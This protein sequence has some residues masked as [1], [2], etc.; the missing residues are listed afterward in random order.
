VKILLKKIAILIV[1]IL[2][3]TVLG[4]E[5]SES[6]GLTGISMLYLLLVVG[7]AYH[8]SPFLVVIV[9]ITSFLVMNYFF[10]E[11]R[12]TFQIGH[13][14]SWTSLISFLIVSVVI[15]S[16]VKRLKLETYQSQQAYLQA[17]FLRKLAEKLTYADSMQLMLEDCQDLLQKEFSKDVLIIKDGVTVKGQHQLTVEHRNAIAWVQEN[18]KSFG[19]G[20][21]NWPDSN[22]M[23]LPFNRLKSNDPVVLLKEIT[24]LQNTSLFGSIKLAVNQI[25]V[26]YQHLLQKQKALKAET[27]A[28][29]ESIRGALL[30]SIAHDMRT[31]LTSILGAAT[32]LNQTEISFN[33]KEMNHL[34]TIISSQAKH[35]ARTTENIL[36]LVRLESVSK[37]SITMDI[38]SPEEIVGILANLYQYQTNSSKLSIKVNQPDLLIE[39]NSDLIVLALTNL[40]E[41]AKQAN[42]DNNN[43]SALIEI[44]VGK[45][46]GKVFIQVCD[47]GRGFEDGFNVSKIKKFESSREKGFGLGLS[48][49]DAVAKLHHAE[50]VFDK[51]KNM[52]AVVSLIFS[53]PDVDLA[54]VG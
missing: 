23:I 22:F 45:S 50:I 33:A 16:L 27:Q 51:G 14:A 52:G 44:I 47:N 43:S 40:I 35:L 11:P 15:T 54:H 25:S 13:I 9:A 53:M 49:V 20:T 37:D 8:Y 48:I 2:F 34:T 31:P 7:V 17:E 28:R 38:Q 4:Y 29:E 26:A 41:N 39:A 18:G 1:L 32:T 5:W 3:I 19:G 6:L 30:A 12:F 21:D 46:D 36:S 10:V 24:D 42:I